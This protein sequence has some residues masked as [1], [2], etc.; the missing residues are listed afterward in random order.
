MAS[1]LGQPI[2]HF[3]STNAI[4]VRCLE[5]PLPAGVRANPHTILLIHGLTSIAETWSLVAPRLA[6]AG[7]RVLA[8]DLRGHGDSDKPDSGY[9]FAN[10]TKD[11]DG[12]LQRLG[13]SRAI[14]VGQSW[15]AGVAAELAGHRPTL[16][17]HL[18]LVDGGFARGGPPAEEPTPERL[19]Q[20]LAP[21]DVYIT[22]Q[23]YLE[24]S[25]GSIPISPELTAI[26][27]SSI[28]HNDD[29]SVREKLLRDHQKLIAREMLTA[30][31]Q[32]RY[33]RIQ[34]PVLFLPAENSNPSAAQR[35]AEK[36]VRVEETAAMLA[37]ASVLWVPDTVHDIQLHKPHEIV[38]AIKGFVGYE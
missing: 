22:E 35:L 15:G 3:V 25:Y 6:E 34:C 31:A 1:V 12:M 16:V 5:W 7:F 17:S 2:T 21:L 4:Q 18:V 13:V 24:A 9:D 8:T 28:Y 14:V 37:N 36:R 26:Y 10:I 38:S 20:M 27:L 29:G 23:T 11:L 19:E 30:D 32:Q 33:T